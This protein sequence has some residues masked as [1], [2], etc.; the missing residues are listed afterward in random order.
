MIDPELRAEILR[1]YH[2]ERWK[3]GT[4]ARELRVHH[5]T[6]RRV[7]EQEGKPPTPARRPRLID[8]FLPFLEETLRKHPRVPASRLYDMVR[9]R[10]YTGQP[11]QFRHLV[12]T[13][14]PRPPAEAYLRLR[15]LPAEEAQVDWAHFGR[16]QIG[17]ASRPLMA[18]VLVLSYSRAI[19][20]RFFLSQK[21][22]DF[23]YGHEFAFRWFGGVSRV[24]LYDNLK[25]VVIER[26]GK[27]I[28]FHPEFVRFAGHYR[29]QP[30]P[31]G[32]ARGNEKGR[33]ERAIRDLRS[34]FFPARRY[35]DLEDLN[36]QATTWCETLSLERRW[37]EDTRRTVG[38]IYREEREKL[39]P[40]PDNP[41][42]CEDRVEVTVGKSPY[43]R[44]DRNDYSVPH[45]L[46]GRTLVL[47]ASLD[48]VRILDRNEA[49]AVHRRSYDRDQRI[50][51]PSH[52][53][54]LVEAKKAA[55]KHR[56]TD[57]LAQVVPSSQKLLVQ[58]ADRGLPLG[59]ATSELE[60]LLR[61]YG[62]EELERAIREALQHETP[63]T[64]AVR[65]ILDRDRKRAGRPPARPLALPDDPRVRDLF[66]QPHDL[67]TYE[68]PKEKEKSDDDEDRNNT[69]G[70]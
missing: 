3:V 19:F 12:A 36:R 59:R 9:E 40:L 57:R 62:P 41:Y 60:E 37:P 68:F 2:A 69:P 63:H 52:V 11:S 46:V 48:T 16:L 28:R 31:V 34:R 45:T 7:L 49:V 20:V 50:E 43:V 14:R 30:R 35:R 10:G 15:T 39:L 53:Q 4:I 6:V 24:C 64:Q 38:E 1:L 18:F 42:P 51:D 33:G 5:G 55:G 13:L 25:S 21:L 8:P 70:T 54:A 17:R 22:S 29:F 27:A 67:R 58:I 65:H 23:L 56:R 61:S 26:A 44:Y 32:V 66:V 47:V